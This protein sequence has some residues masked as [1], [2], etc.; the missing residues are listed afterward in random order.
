MTM[1]AFV[2]FDHGIEY[3][4]RCSGAKAADHGRFV[5]SSFESGASSG[6]MLSSCST[7]A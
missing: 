4:T 1:V 2:A 6:A 5:Q 7:A 3:P